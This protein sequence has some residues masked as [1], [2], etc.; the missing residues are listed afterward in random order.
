MSKE[1]TTLPSGLQYYRD[2]DQ[3]GH[4]VMVNPKTIKRYNE[5]KYDKGAHPDASQY[6]VFF[7][8]S[9]KQF[10]EGYNSLVKRGYIKDGDKVKK[11]VA[12]LFG[13]FEEIKRFYEFYR[14]RDELVKAECDP[15]EVYF[16]EYNNY[17]CMYSY[18]GDQEAYNAVADIW[19]KDI[20][21]KLYRLRY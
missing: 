8:F 4:V 11:A 7:A 9:D 15:Q 14:E 18:E 20:A 6:G 17:E 5:L 10:D 19:D 3:D 21:N 1:I 13:T 16:Y 12:G 2:W